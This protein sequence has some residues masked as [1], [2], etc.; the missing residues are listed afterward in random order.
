[1]DRHLSTKEPWLLFQQNSTT[2]DGFHPEEQ[3]ALQH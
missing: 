2:V 3:S 1:M